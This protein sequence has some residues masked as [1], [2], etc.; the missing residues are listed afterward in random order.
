MLRPGYFKIVVWVL[1]NLIAARDLGL[2]IKIL[3]N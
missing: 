2:K 3:E 1:T